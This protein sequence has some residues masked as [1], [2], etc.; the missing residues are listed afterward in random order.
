MRPFVTW[1]AHGVAIKAF[2]WSWHNSFVNDKVTSNA[3]NVWVNENYNRNNSWPGGFYNREDII[4]DNDL[5]L[6]RLVNVL[7]KDAKRLQDRAASFRPTFGTWRPIMMPTITK[8]WPLTS[9]TFRLKSFN[10]S[11]KSTNKSM[12]LPILSRAAVTMALPATALLSIRIT[13]VVR[14]T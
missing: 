9:L 5:L 10:P 14:Q 2:T 4:K 3:R 11:R 6:V 12:R 7:S 8:P 13:I 1:L